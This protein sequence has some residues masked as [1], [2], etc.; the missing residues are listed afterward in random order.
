[1][2]LLSQLSRPIGLFALLAC[3]GDPSAPP[4]GALVDQFGGPGAALVATAA[5]VRLETVCTPIVFPQA[6]VPGPRGEFAL[7]PVLVPG[8]QRFAAAIRGVVSGDVLEVELRVLSGTAD[9]GGSSFRLTRGRPADYGNS[10]CAVGA[11]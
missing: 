4:L 2:S 1:M 6:L 5:G 11:E 10:A 7:G 8:N 9:T 3:R